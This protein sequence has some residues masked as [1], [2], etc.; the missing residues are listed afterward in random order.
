VRIANVLMRLR[1]LQVELRSEIGPWIVWRRYRQ[2]HELDCNL[3]ERYSTCTSCA[4]SA[5]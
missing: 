1:T 4:G 5:A 3:K 2:F